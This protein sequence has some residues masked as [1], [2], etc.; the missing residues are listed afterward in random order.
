M[1]AKLSL[2]GIDLSRQSYK[3][4]AYVTSVIVTEKTTSGTFPLS[5]G[6][7]GTDGDD[8][9]SPDPEVGEAHEESTPADREAVQLDLAGRAPV[10]LYDGDPGAWL[11]CRGAV[12][13]TDGGVEKAG[14]RLDETRHVMDTSLLG[15]SLAVGVSAPGAATMLSADAL[16]TT[17]GLLAYVGDEVLCLFDVRMDSVDAYREKPAEFTL[18]LEDGTA[19]TF[20]WEVEGLPAEDQPEV[21]EGQP[22]GVARAWDLASAEG[23]DRTVGVH[24]TPDGTNVMGSTDSSL[25]GLSS[26]GPTTR[27]EPAPA[28]KEVEVP[29]PVADVPPAEVPARRG[30]SNPPRKAA[31]AP[32]KTE[33]GSA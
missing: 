14:A 29:S 13:G 30:F 2:V 28:V 12:M 21:P 24:V 25:A 1:N 20:A 15:Q 5:I 4:D 32:E 17:A 22:E 27:A 18:D 16:L 33:P 23:G 9:E 11:V 6:S 10:V 3:R 19:V 31:P 8:P 26:A 7:W